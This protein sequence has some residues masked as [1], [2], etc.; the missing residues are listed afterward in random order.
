MA[1]FESTVIISD[2]QYDL[3]EITAEWITKFFEFSSSW[4]YSTWISDCTPL[5]EIEYLE[6]FFRAD[7]KE[8]LYK[9]ED[10][11]LLEYLGDIGGLLDFVLIF[12]WFLSHK[13]VAR[14]L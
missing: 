8:K 12:G 11:S 13:F 1:F 2:N 10:Y 5:E 6:I 9:R 7:N 3:F 14:M 4:T